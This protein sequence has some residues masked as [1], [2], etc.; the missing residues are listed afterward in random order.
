[1]GG[2]QCLGKTL[3][4]QQR[5]SENILE[6]I[7]VTAGRVAEEAVSVPV[8]VTVITSEDIQRLNPYDLSALLEHFGIQVADYGAHNGFAVVT[9]R[10]FKNGEQASDIGDVLF[11]VDGRRYGLNNPGTISMENIERVEIIRGAVSM[12][13]GPEAVGGVVNLISRRGT[14]DFKAKI[15]QEIGSF[16]TARTKASFSGRVQNFDFSLGGQYA[17]SSSYSLANGAIFAN[18]GLP[19][20]VVGSANL[21]YNFTED[22]RIGF[23]FN[24]FDGVMNRSGGMRPTAANPYAVRYPYGEYQRKNWNWDLNYNGAIPENNLTFLARFHKGHDTYIGTEN[25]LNYMG[26]RYSN[27]QHD[28]QGANLNASWNNGIVYLTGGFDYY[29]EEMNK[30]SFPTFSSQKDLAAFLI[31][32]ISLLNDTL[33][34]TGGI[35]YDKFTVELEGL[36]GVKTS[37]LTRTTPSFGVAYSPVH[38]LRLRGNYSSAYR[39]PTPNQMAADY[40]TSGR[41]LIGNPNIKP[42]SATTFEGGFDIAIHEVNLAVTYFNTNY[43]D[44]I[45]E[46]PLCP[47]CDPPQ[48]TYR[49]VASSQFR[50]LEL[51]FDW[52][53]GLYFGWP[54]SLKPS[55][56]LTKMLKYHSNEGGVDEEIVL[57]SDLNMSYGVRFSYPDIGLNASIDADYFGHQWEL[58]RTFKVG[59]NT[60]YSLHIDKEL[61]S[62]QDAGKFTLGVDIKNLTNVDYQTINPYP[63]AGRHFLLSLSY[64][65]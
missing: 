46:A 48:S 32:K 61:L 18:T 47:T 52:D 14:E 24:Y 20:K 22:H 10:G 39:L 37:S 16:S 25:R 57:I 28:Y 50:G 8:A 4:A 23:V 41:H 11:L 49:N 26:G 40:I 51:A 34:L 30:T 6:E 44:M 42:Q 55:I 13:Y 43:K 9:I 12:Q 21:G 65:Y 35:R 63:Q 31:A 56:Y 27:I 59:G 45:V 19:H 58:Y 5:Q 15:T 17:R 1:M 54:F 38:W 64:E 29:L 3:I 2:F 53:L 33:W 36:T 60:V 7:V 62:L